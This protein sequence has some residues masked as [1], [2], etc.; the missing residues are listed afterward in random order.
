MTLFGIGDETTHRAGAPDCPEC[1][2]EYPEPCPCG[3][4]IHAA[5]GEEDEDGNVALETRCDSCG[6]TEGE[7]DRETELGERAP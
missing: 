4:L 3:G 7:L 2:E 5:A 1:W 6:R